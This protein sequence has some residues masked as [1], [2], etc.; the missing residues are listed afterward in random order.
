MIRISDAITLAYTKLKTRRLRTLVTIIIA[1]LLFGVIV[2]GVIFLQG[3]LNSMN[4]FSANSLSGRYLTAATYNSNLYPNSDVLPDSVK[5]RSLEI[6]NKLITDK[7][8]AAKEIGAYYDPTSEQKPISKFGDEEYFDTSSPA[9]IQAFNEYIASQ[10]TSK[11]NLEEIVDSFK[12]IKSYEILSTPSYYNQIKM[13][14]TDKGEL[15]AGDPQYPNDGSSPDVSFGWV[16]MDQ[17]VTKPFMIDQKQIDEQTNTQDIPIIA[18]IEQVES[19]LGLKKILT[20]A[21]SKEKLDRITYI[22]DNAQKATFSICYRNSVSKSQIQ[23]AIDT[24][25][26]IDANKNNKDFQKPSLIYGLPDDTKSCAP[27]TIISDTRTKLEKLYDDKQ[28]QLKAMFSEETEPIQQKITFRT[29]GL[30]PNNLS[31]YGFSSISGLIS[32]IAGSTL[33]GRWVVPQ[34]LFDAMPNKQ[35]Y[36][37]LLSITSKEI[38][39]TEIKYDSSSMI[40]EFASATQAKEFVD[41]VGCGNMYCDGQ[42]SAIYFGINSVLIEE[43]RTQAAKILDYITLAIAAIASIIMTG[44]VGRVIGDSR[45]ETA[46]FRAIGAKRND[47]RL[48]YVSYTIMLSIVII[49]ASLIIGTIAAS[50]IN[51]LMSPEASV[52]AH[53]SYI[54]ADDKMSFSFIGIW[55]ESLSLLS[56]LIIL[57]GLTGMLLPLSRNLARSPIKDMRDDT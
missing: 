26:L 13:I 31:A 37:R 45:R 43:I 51:G 14:T 16:Y 23:S 57:S 8:A 28:N 55:W 15:F 47:I 24:A 52:Q 50:Y 4:N 1:S 56:G 53:L 19:A 35:E 2:L 39:S 38:S 46:V 44:M 34:Q 49:M 6:Y 33:E 32:S 54:F 7:K 48:I 22:R 5:T 41:K 27:A 42:K 18:P 20:N 17:S 40:V 29:V 12:P 3:A 9:T 36:A 25:K 11:Q 30:S 21:S 10:P